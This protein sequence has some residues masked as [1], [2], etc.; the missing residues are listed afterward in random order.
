MLEISMF[1]QAVCWWF[2]CF[3]DEWNVLFTRTLPMRW[4]Q[5]LM[6]PREWCDQQEKLP[7]FLNQARSHCSVGL[8]QD[9]GSSTTSRGFNTP[10]STVWLEDRLSGLMW[11][12]DAQ[13]YGR[14]MVQL[15]LWLRRMY[16]YPSLTG[17]GGMNVSEGLCKSTGKLI[18]GCGEASICDSAVTSGLNLLFRP[19]WIQLHGVVT[20][21]P[22]LTSRVWH[23]LE[24]GITTTSV[25]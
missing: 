2:R 13:G 20:T 15:P 11:T 18:P 14:C 12:L 9:V 7:E 8:W 3:C 1:G 17:R 16:G 19:K 22:V 10:H 24:T 5:T 6:W 23:E 25:M 21:S 4:T